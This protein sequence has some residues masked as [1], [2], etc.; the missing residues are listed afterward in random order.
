MSSLAPLVAHDLS[1]SYGD[2][3][4][5]DGVDLI[6]NLGEPTGLVGENGVGKSTLLRLLLGLEDRDSGS[7]SLPPEVGYVAQ[8]LDLEPVAT[9]GEVLR[10][11]LAPLHDAVRRLEDL[12]HR[13]DDPVAADEYAVT[14]E[15]ATQHD[16]WDADR[17]ADQASHH[18]GLATIDKTRPVGELS[19][20][21]RTR[22]ALAALI[23]R[24]PGCVILDEP[25]NHLDDDAI[26]FLESFLLDL[27]G[28][29]LVASHDRVFLDRVCSVIVDLDASQWR[30][31]ERSGTRYRGDFAVYLEHKA[32]ARRRWE[33]TFAAQK[34]ELN[35]LRRSA[36]TTARQVGHASRP[37]RDNDKYIVHA[38]T[39]IKQA[40]VSRRVRNVER[41]I[42][43]LERD[44]VRRPPRELSFGQP[45]A[46]K[47]ASTGLVVFVRDLRV[48]GRVSVD[49]LDLEAGGHLLVTGSNGSGKSSLLAV[50]AGHLG[51]EAGTVSVAARKVGMLAQDVAFSDPS[52]TPQQVYDAATGAPVPLRE[53]GLLHPRE[54]TRPLGVLSVGQQRRLALA[55]LVAGG[56]DLLLLDEPTNHISLTLAGELESALGRST[57]TVIVASHDRWLRQRW[58]GSTLTL[59]R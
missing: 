46:G 42:D 27:P 30:A 49:R 54:V 6:A 22:L 29:V 24:R 48:R 23:A 55:I 34:D 1:K 26:E 2:R 3:V 16:A 13:L 37:P 58:T 40:A 28:V 25:T 51:P 15:W 59:S 12:A 19:G 32:A 53:L 18:L 47:T 33:E 9:V 11:A 20:G 7:V 45:I 44:Q 10:A 57:G 31:D 4:V 52:R 8:D 14:L 50:L 38:K 21:E 41:R 39:Q 56:V 35:A 36:R 43:A 5:L 17:R